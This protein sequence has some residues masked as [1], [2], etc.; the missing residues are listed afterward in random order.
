MSNIYIA[1]A[2]VGDKINDV[3]YDAKDDSIQIVVSNEGSI[4]YCPY[5]SINLGTLASILEMMP[6]EAKDSLANLTK[7]PQTGDT[8]VVQA[9]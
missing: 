5:I 8:S 4:A 9:C 2:T 7:T 6:Q 3:R 1:T